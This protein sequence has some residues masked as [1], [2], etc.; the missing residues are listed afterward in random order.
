MD[1]CNNVYYSVIL[2]LSIV[3]LWDRASSINTEGKGILV[4]KWDEFDRKQ[5][6]LLGGLKPLAAQIHGRCPETSS[7]RTW[8]LV[9]ELIF[10]NV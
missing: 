3:L 8:A 9:V 1:D 4:M 5:P 7:H 10:S 2:L 6:V